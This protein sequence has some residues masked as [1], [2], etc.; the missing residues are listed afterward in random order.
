MAIL[1]KIRDRSMFLILIVGLALFAFVLDPSSV[2][3]FFSSSKINSIGE[4]NGD[5]I[6]REIIKKRAV[7]YAKQLMK[8]MYLKSF[9]D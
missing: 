7:I 2:Q 3:N 6:D 9:S 4:V 8:T 1:S 5:E